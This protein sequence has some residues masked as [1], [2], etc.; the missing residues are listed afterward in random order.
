MKILGEPCGQTRA[1][2]PAARAESL[3][4]S[5]GTRARRLREVR[6]PAEKEKMIAEALT[7]LK[8]HALLES[9]TD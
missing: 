7:E 1:S 4:E 2:Y 9:G 6:I 5:K 8:V 3:H